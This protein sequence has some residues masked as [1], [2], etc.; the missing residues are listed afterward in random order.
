[1]TEQPDPDSCLIYVCDNCGE[2]KKAPP[3][4]QNLLKEFVTLHGNNI[5]H[6]L[7]TACTEKLHPQ[8]ESE[9]AY[10]SIR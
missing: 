5:V 1:M 9:A 6:D 10:G 2:E 4:M 8:D 7:C 3:I